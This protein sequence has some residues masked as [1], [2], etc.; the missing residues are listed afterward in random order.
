[1]AGLSVARTVHRRGNGV[2]PLER[3]RPLLTALMTL[4]MLLTV[5]AAMVA[6]SR[7]AWNARTLAS[8][9]LASNTDEQGTT[10]VYG[11]PQYSEESTPLL[12]GVLVHSFSE[13]D[14]EDEC[15]AGSFA[16]V[17]L[18]VWPVGSVG[19]LLRVC[20]EP[21]RLRTVYEYARLERPG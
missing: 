16:V 11:L 10:A 21:R 15:L 5:G 20:G 2:A 8:R 4:T 17:V 3:Y 19:G 14:N 6:P 1:M 18:V 12:D 7:A 9:T 13:E